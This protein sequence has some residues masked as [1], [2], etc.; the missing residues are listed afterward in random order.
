MSSPSKLRLASSG[1]GGGG[2]AAGLVFTK[3]PVPAKTFDTA[4]GF[5]A[6]GVA[7]PL[8]R[9]PNWPTGSAAAATGASFAL[10]VRMLGGRSEHEAS[11][12]HP[13]IHAASA[14]DRVRYGGLAGSVILSGDRL[15]GEAM[16][17]LHWF[18]G[19]RRALRRSSNSSGVIGAAAASVVARAAG[20]ELGVPAGCGAFGCAPPGRGRAKGGNTAAGAAACGAP[21]AGAAGAPGAAAGV[22]DAK[23]PPW[24]VAAGAAA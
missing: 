19:V 1:P 22:V 4:G 24:G 7:G 8:G 17:T 14:G 21:G 5:S 18:C 12:M 3:L 9:G 16:E 20:F 11:S 13:A 2:A 15:Y 23:G 10:S 6:G